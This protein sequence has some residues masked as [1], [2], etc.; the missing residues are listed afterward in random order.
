MCLCTYVLA[1]E[2]IDANHCGRTADSNPHRGEM[3]QTVGWIRVIVATINKCG[4]LRSL[5]S[6]RELNGNICKRRLTTSSIFTVNDN[7]GLGFETKQTNRLIFDSANVI[8]CLRHGA[9][10]VT[11]K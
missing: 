7:V 4:L 1:Y 6:H 5:H 11:L 2:W 3:S 8:S 9:S 10:L